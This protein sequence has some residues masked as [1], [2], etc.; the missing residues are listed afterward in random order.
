MISNIDIQVV[1]ALSDVGIQPVQEGKYYKPHTNGYYRFFKIGVH[2]LRKTIGDKI[3][4]EVEV[5]NGKF[6]TELFSISGL[7]IL[8]NKENL[9]EYINTRIKEFIYKSQ[10]KLK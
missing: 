5:L 8:Q 2:P 7:E 9:E 6:S 1:K 3:K 10:E 4:R